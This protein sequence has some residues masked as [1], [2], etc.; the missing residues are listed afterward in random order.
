[1]KVKITSPG[2][3]AKEGKAGENG[4]E[5]RT[6][7]GG[8]PVAKRYVATCDDEYLLKACAS[9][10]EKTA[11]CNKNSAAADPNI[12]DPRV[13]RRTGGRNFTMRAQI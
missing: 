11:F 2:G 9:R 12:G 1:M 5:N 4:T 13:K 7:T 10:Q 3:S 8:N 6:E